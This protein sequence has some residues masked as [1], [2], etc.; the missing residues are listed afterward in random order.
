MMRM[1]EHGLQDRQNARLYTRKPKCGGGGSFVNVG[2]VDTRGAM[3]VMAW[4][5]GFSGIIF[6][7]ELLLKK[8]TSKIESK[9]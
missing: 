6:I 3:L 9:A 7:L 4:G 5:F 1:H 2:L 8:I